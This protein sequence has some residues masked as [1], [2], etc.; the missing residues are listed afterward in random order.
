LTEDFGFIIEKLTPSSSGNDIVWDMTTNRFALIDATDHTK[1]VYSDPTKDLS[2]NPI[3]LW[4]VFKEVPSEETQKYS[5][6]LAGE[7]FTSPIRTSVGIDVGKNLGITEINYTNTSGP[8]QEVVI[9]TNSA[10]TELV[11]NAP[12]DTVKHYG[13]VG[14]VDAQKVDMN[15]YNEYG[16]ASYVKVTEGKVVAKA[17]GKINTVFANNTDGTKV[18]VIKESGAE[19]KNGYTTVQETHDKNLERDNGVELVY[20]DG[21]TPYTETEIEKIGSLAVAADTGV[22]PENSDYVA[23]VN[24]VGYNSLREA[25]VAANAGDIVSLLK[26]NTENTSAGTIKYT[27]LRS[28]TPEAAI[29]IN[30][31]ITIKGFDH[32]F[33]TNKTIAIAINASNLVVKII[34]L[35]IE[36]ATSAIQYSEDIVGGAI[37]VEGSRLHVSSSSG[38]AFR[39]GN[40]TKNL[41]VTIKDTTLEGW[42]AFT[43]RSSNSTFKIIDSDLRGENDTQQASS[44]DYAAIVFDGANYE[45]HYSS[46]TQYQGHSGICGSNNTMEI[47]NTKVSATSSTSNSQEWLSM[48]FGARNNKVVVDSLSIINPVAKW[49]YSDLDDGSTN[50]IIINNAEVSGESGI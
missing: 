48:Q 23:V 22:A 39:T 25:V 36:A 31:N 46:S 26:D 50:T 41:N 18:A 42:S 40:G 47:I 5:I 21:V 33:K 11:V 10:K 12:N 49:I 7:N 34:D 45:G 13:V 9:R 6:Y 17:G 28:Q 15:S 24:N 43:I 32:K 30:K 37:S 1:V 4:K 16:E 38:Y 20:L 29:I 2:D 8:K 3:N 35:D 27:S 14:K 19:I 44:N